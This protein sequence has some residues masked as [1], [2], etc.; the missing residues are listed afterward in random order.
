[1]V[2]FEYGDKRRDEI[3]CGNAILYNL[4]LICGKDSKKQQ[5][6]LSSFL[7]K[8]L[9]F[10]T[11]RKGT[12]NQ[13]VNSSQE[14]LTH[15]DENGFLHIHVIGN[16][17]Q[18]K[19]DEN[20]ILN[21][22]THECCHAFNH[23]LQQEHS[24]YPK[25]IIK[26]GIFYYPSMGMIGTKDA[27][28]MK[29]IR[30]QFYGDMFRES[31]MDI[32]TN[33]ALVSFEPNYTE[34]GI[35][36]DTVLKNPN[37][38]RKVDSA[39]SRFDP[40]IQLAISAFSNDSSISYKNL[41][42]SGIGI[43][44]YKVKKTNGKDVMANDF[45]YGIM[46]DPFHIESE[47]N[48]CMSD[49][50]SYQDLTEFIDTVYK[51]GVLQEKLPEANIKSINFIIDQFSEFM[52]RKCKL[53]VQN[54]LYTQEEANRL[55]SNYNSIYNEVIKIYES[56]KIQNVNNNSVVRP[57]E[58]IDLGMRE[59]KKKPGSISTGIE[60]TK[61]IFSRIFYKNKDERDEN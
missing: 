30:K 14:G 6:L 59:M 38:K 9:T 60:K 23:L 45:L 16:G 55:I 58:I 13:Y 56:E 35:N 4:R 52:N 20:K 31:L 12:I 61:A 17:A 33:V 25:G 21:H 22:I 3:V 47:W 37:T 28:T 43:Y 50:V 49:E 2:K 48:R 10:Q 27:K 5:E 1:M 7:D 44:D 18:V 54:G 46:C 51:S 41:I 32:M 40:L 8:V 42:D 19:D 53:N 24:M 39:M 26:D 29:P 34:Q 15:L 11:Y 36:A 57:T